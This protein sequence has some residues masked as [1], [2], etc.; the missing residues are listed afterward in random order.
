MLRNK[1]SIQNR[2]NVV[3]LLDFFFGGGLIFFVLLVFE[4]VKENVRERAEAG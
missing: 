2:L 3:G 4:Q 1:W